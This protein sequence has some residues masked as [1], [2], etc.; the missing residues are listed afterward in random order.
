MLLGNTLSVARQ[1]CTHLKE[2]ETRPLVSAMREPVK[3]VRR[4]EPL[5]DLPRPDLH[6]TVHTQGVRDAR[7]QCLVHV[8]EDHP[9]P[10]QRVT[11]LYPLKTGLSGMLDCWRKVREIFMVWDDRFTS[12]LVR[13]GQLPAPSNPRHQTEQKH[14]NLCHLFA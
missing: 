6:F 2:D 13:I 5:C 8:A 9:S 11:R 7:R 3:G 12:S 14:Q 10:N 4:P 1:H